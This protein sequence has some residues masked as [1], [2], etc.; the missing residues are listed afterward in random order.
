MFRYGFTLLRLISPYNVTKLSFFVTNEVDFDIWITE[1][2][3]R[4][5]LLIS[6]IDF[7]FLLV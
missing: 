2:C 6:I 5:I 3:I 1:L 7:G 4:I